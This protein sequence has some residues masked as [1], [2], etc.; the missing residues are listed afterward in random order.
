M[1]TI[2]IS[3]TS[4][5]VQYTV[6]GTPTTG[7]WT[8]TF[9]FFD[10]DDLLV[11]ED[12]TL[13]TRDVDYSVSGTAVDDGY[14]GGTIT[15]LSSISSVTL[16]IVRDIPV[17]RTTDFPTSGY[18]DIAAL[19]TA[20]DKI[21]AIQQEL[22][23]KLLRAVKLAD[24]DSNTTPGDLPTASDGKALYWNGTT[25][26]NSTVNIEDL[27]TAVTD[28]QA[29]ETAA[30]AAQAAAEAAL[31][32]FDDIYLG[33]KA[34]APTL[35]NDGDPLAEGTLYWNSTTNELNVYNGSAWEAAAPGVS[36][37]LALSGGAMTGPITGSHGLLDSV[38]TDTTPQLGGDLDANGNNINVTNGTDPTGDVTD[39]FALFSKDINGNAYPHARPEGGSNVP[40]VLT[41]KQ[42]VWLPARA[43]LPRDT[44]GAEAATRELAT[45]DVMLESLNFDA[46]TKEYA[47]LELD[48]PKDYDGGTI[49]VNFKWTAA[50]GSGD[51]VWGLQAVCVGDDDALD[52]AMGTAQTVTDTLTAADDLCQTSETSAITISAAAAQEL[53]IIT[54]YRDA[55]AGGDTLAVDAELIGVRLTFTTDLPNED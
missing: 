9:P 54:V 33:S 20:L 15:W 21:I 10:L 48:L 36:G 40:I 23:T 3:D 2:S 34:S 14:S 28:A 27:A 24:T 12:D 18:F 26:D 50:S 22:E 35:D 52:V 39:G 30:Q 45:N 29:A 44:N 55:A 31:D 11:Y 17:E 32:E 37:Y 16:T 4:P 13:K 49:T 46:A 5:R 1:A 43:F 41:G 7:P 51:V 38:V 25:L 42:S 19:N 8:I 6:G 53:C 47:Q